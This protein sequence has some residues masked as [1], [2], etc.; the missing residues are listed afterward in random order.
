MNDDFRQAAPRENGSRKFR[1]YG[2]EFWRFFD[3]ALR[4]YASSLRAGDDRD[5]LVRRAA[6]ALI[7]HD[8]FFLMTDPHGYIL[9][10]F[11]E[12]DILSCVDSWSVEDGGLRLCGKGILGWRRFW[13][14]TPKAW[15]LI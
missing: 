10:G 5:E 13:S 9:E 3:I 7:R 12:E 6:L 11:S 14:G 15:K 4:G 1:K 2:D 8:P